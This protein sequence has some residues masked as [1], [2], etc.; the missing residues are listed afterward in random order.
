MM[1][2]KSLLKKIAQALGVYHSIRNRLKAYRDKRELREWRELGKPVPPPHMVKQRAILKYAREFK[3]EALVETGTYLGDMVA[4]MIEDF[5]TIHT[6]ELDTALFHSARKR[7]KNRPNVLLYH[8]DSGVVINDVLSVIGESPGRVVFWLDGHYSGGITATSKCPLVEE[9][10]T[11]LTRRPH[12]V[13][14]IDDVHCFGVAKDYPTVQSI[15]EMV[16][17]LS[18]GAK[19]QVE[20][21]I[22]RIFPTL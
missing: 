19:L 21:N 14:L 5:Q 22:L 13:I 7:F 17:G 8:G 18:P 12:D 1:K 16:V 3:C 15:E 4:A 11:I 2:I 6:I 10:R 20:D 9:V